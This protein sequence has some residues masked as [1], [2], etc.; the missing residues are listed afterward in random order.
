VDGDVL[1]QC[2]IVVTEYGVM[3]PR[4]GVNDKAGPQRDAVP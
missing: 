1:Q 3:K 4:K 2:E